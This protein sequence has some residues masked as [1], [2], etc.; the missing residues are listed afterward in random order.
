M[1]DVAMVVTIHNYDDQ[2]QQIVIATEW[3][4]DEAAVVISNEVPTSDS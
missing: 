1:D 4:N 2:R 3:E